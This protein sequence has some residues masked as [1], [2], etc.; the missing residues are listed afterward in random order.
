MQPT[1]H[2]RNAFLFVMQ[3]AI[4]PDMNIEAS[5][6]G[7]LQR[8]VVQIR[9]RPSEKSAFTLAAE[10]AG[11]SLSAWVRERLR[12]TAARELESA[13]RKIPFLKDITLE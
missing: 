12:Q 3:S 7:D 2:K 1:I 9:V 13:G 5:D 6:E 4:L 10:I 11:I 8:E